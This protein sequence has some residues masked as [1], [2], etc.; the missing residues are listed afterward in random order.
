MDARASDS[1]SSARRT[2]INLFSPDGPRVRLKAG[3]AR[4]LILVSHFYEPVTS[5]NQSSG[6][7]LTLYIQLSIRNPILGEKGST[8]II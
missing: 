4:P 3:I 1:Q 2:D 8:V 5:A 6:I 7:F